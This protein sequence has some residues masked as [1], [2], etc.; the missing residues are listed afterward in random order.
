MI[1]AG[2]GATGIESDLQMAF[3]ERFG[4]IFSQWVKTRKMPLIRPLGP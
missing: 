3:R 1:V 2:F 4:F